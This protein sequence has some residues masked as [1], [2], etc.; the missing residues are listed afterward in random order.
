VPIE[1]ASSHMM[2]AMTAA[3]ENRETG[4]Y[5]LLCGAEVIKVHSFVLAARWDLDSHCIDLHVAS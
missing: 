5:T 4:D 2:S 1:M 3:L